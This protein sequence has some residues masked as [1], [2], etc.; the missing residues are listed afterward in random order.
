MLSFRRQMY[1][2]AENLSKLPDSMLINYDST[3]HRIF[4]ADDFIIC[5]TCKMSG[6]IS[7]NCPKKPTETSKKSQD[8]SPQAPISNTTYNM[9]HPVQLLNNTLHNSMEIA[10]ENNQESNDVQNSLIQL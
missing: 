1:I 6:H 5:F 9:N 8:E 4:L 3:N 10:Y 2:A 7:A